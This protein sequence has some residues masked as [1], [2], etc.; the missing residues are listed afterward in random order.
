MQNEHDPHKGHEH[1]HHGHGMPTMAMPVGKVKDP[2][3]GMIIDPAKAAAKTEMRNNC[4]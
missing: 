4:G 3:C 2:V 1:A